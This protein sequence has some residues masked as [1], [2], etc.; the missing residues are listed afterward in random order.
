M[1]NTKSKVFVILMSA[2]VVLLAMFAAKTFSGVTPDYSGEESSGASAKTSENPGEDS[3]DPMSPGEGSSTQSPPE[4]SGEEPVS[5][6]K[7]ASQPEESETSKE[8]EPGES[9]G[10]EPSEPAVSEDPKIGK[11]EEPAYFEKQDGVKY[12]AFTFDDG[13][14]VHTPELLDYLEEAQIPVTFFVVGNRLENATYGSYVTRAVGLG[15]EIGSHGYSHE[16]YFDRCT[17]DEYFTELEKTADLIYQYAGYYP[18]LMRPPGGSITKARAAASEYNVII[19]WVDSQDW[20]LS[21]RA[22][23]KTKNANIQ[24]IVDN[25]LD[26]VRSTSAEPIVLMHDLYQN[27]VEAFKIASQA[28][29]EEGYQFVTVAQ[30]CG[31]DGTTTVGKRYWSP[32]YKD[33]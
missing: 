18:I 22:D 13:P 25:I 31:L 33:N 32:T 16:V 30:L 7:P 14:S 12:I 8:P 6:D 21:S 4:S 9:S 26:G 19:W 3:S 28:L 1:R 10:E 24:T 5:R 11:K 20:K 15:C 23:E 27:S 17:D 2:V 29:I